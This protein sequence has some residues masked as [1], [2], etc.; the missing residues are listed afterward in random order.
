M[1]PRLQERKANPPVSE[2]VCPGRA[3]GF[4]LGPVIQRML[5]VPVQTPQCSQV[6]GQHK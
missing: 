2:M 6:L 4:E 3:E 1:L 5:Q